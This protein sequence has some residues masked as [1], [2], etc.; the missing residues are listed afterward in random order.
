LLC[1]CSPIHLLS[2]I[3]GSWLR[4]GK[5]DCREFYCDV[6]LAMRA[7]FLGLRRLMSSD[8]FGEQVHGSKARPHEQRHGAS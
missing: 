7:V 2:E 5:A 4:F 3:P 8:I 6:F 1:D